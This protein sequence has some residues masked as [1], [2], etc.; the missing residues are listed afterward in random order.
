MKTKSIFIAVGLALSVPA[1]ASAHTIAVVV[2]CNPGSPGATSVL[3]SVTQPSTGMA[4]ATCP[5]GTYPAASAL[6]GT[7]AL[8]GAITAAAL[9]GG[10]ALADSGSSGSGSSGSGSGSSGSGSGTTTYPVTAKNI[11]GLPSPELSPASL[12][13]YPDLDG[14]G[15]GSGS[16][17]SGSGSSGSGS[18]T[19]NGSGGSGNGGFLGKLF[20]TVGKVAQ[21]IG[22]AALTGGQVSIPL[23]GGSGPGG[24]A[25]TTGTGA[26]TAGEQASGGSTQELLLRRQMRDIPGTISLAGPTNPYFHVTGGVDALYSWIAREHTS[27]N[28]LNF[29]VTPSAVYPAVYPVGNSVYEYAKAA[30]TFDVYVDEGAR[31][32]VAYPGNPVPFAALVSMSGVNSA[33]QGA[34]Q[35]IFQSAEATYS[36]GPQHWNP[37]GDRNGP[38][39]PSPADGGSAITT[40][41]SADAGTDLA[42]VGS[43]VCGAL[44]NL[45]H[46]SFG[47]NCWISH[48]PSG[49]PTRL[50][51]GYNSNSQN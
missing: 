43:G 15:N 45:F 36:G 48:F 40:V 25:S 46:A 30:G 14:S 4:T 13:N 19:G 44:Q 50:F 31:K 23:F 33:I 17:G 1:A 35:S 28:L 29:V 5:A 7:P 38:F 22:H 16:S 39:W 49:T 24:T 11:P 42:Q 12:A 3:P 47:T 27:F 6:A 26:G 37:P 51:P 18:S 41:P 2:A 20:T 9:G 21:Q 8:V 32:Y 34:A 10:L